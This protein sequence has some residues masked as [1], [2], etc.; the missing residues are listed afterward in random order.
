MSKFQLFWKIRLPNSIPYIIDGMKIS[1][2]LSLIG[3]V[4]GEFVL[5][6]GGLGYL[7]E[8]SSSN[9]DTPL[10]FSALFF[11]SLLGLSMYSV[12]CFLE[13]IIKSKIGGW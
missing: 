11:M 12:V 7:V 4:V 9:F 2:P 1:L 13:K 8:L 6:D 3:A 10:A 5:A